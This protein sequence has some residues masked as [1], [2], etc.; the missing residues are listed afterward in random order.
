L[1]ERYGV[2]TRD[3]VLAE[4]ISGGYAGLYPVL[5]AMEEAGR[6]RRGYFV[7]GLGAAQFAFPGADDRLRTSSAAAN[8]AR[9]SPRED[10]E[11]IVLSAAD[12]AN[13]YGAVLPWPAR[14]VDGGNPQ[15]VAGSRVILR[16]G[17]LLGY[18]GRRSDSLLTY[19][20]ADA[21]TRVNARH[22]LAQSL[23]ALAANGLLVLIAKI[24][25][26]P[27]S[28]S[29]LAEDLIAAGFRPTHR[30]LQFPIKHPPRGHGG[31]PIA[32]N[33][34]DTDHSMW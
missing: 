32:V 15:R 23:A 31:A 30:G 9:E 8:S 25:Q 17:A 22:D 20:P 14:L 2:L 33:I 7:A 26:R 18:L 5:K 6:A 21:E 29:E 1:L 12:P 24:D 16:D 27:A 11:I 28:E 19:L 3:M 34:D 10:A 4:G 13:A